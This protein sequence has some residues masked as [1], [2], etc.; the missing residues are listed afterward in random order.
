MQFSL[1]VLPRAK[2]SQYNLRQSIFVHLQ[3]G[4]Y[5]FSSDYIAPEELIGKLSAGSPGA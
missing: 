3:P 1:Q 2:H 5:L 4:P